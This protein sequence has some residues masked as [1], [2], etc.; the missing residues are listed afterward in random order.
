MPRKTQ[1]PKSR[2]AMILN[3]AKELFYERSFAAVGVDEIGERAGVTG[4]AIY[5]HFAGKDEIL[6]TLFDDAIDRL[7]EATAFRSDD[8][9]EELEA[10]VRGHAEFVLGERKL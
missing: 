6:A 9:W 2:Q 5:R 1:G 10:I 4:P 3:A 7:T 8:P